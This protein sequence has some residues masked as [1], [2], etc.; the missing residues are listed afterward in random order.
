MDIQ[1]KL[2]LV[3]GSA[4]GIGRA[5]A[6]AL[7]ARGAE[8]VVLAD[9]DPAGNAETARLVELAGASP[10]AVNVDISDAASLARLYSDAAHRLGPPDIVLNNAGVVSGNPEWPFTSLARLLQVIAINFG[11]VVVGTRLALE[12]MRGRG[13]TIINV[14][15]MLAFEP[16]PEDP[17]YAATK[18]AV[19]SF[20]RSCAPLADEL[21]IRVNAVCPGVTRT[22]MLGRPGQEADPPPWAMPYVEGL[23]TLD[24][25]EVAA[26]VIAL[27]EDDSRAGDVLVLENVPL[28]N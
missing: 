1:G 22:A 7:A 19:V 25:S 16:L 12:Q 2:A 15:S 23:D 21:G 13:G 20:T 9:L 27:V 18:A 24:P 3:T 28:D 11:G 8:A 4:S 6:L 17:V 5:A 14:A 10:M 26:A